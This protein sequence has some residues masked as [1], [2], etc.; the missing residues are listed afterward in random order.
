MK[1]KTPV[2]IIALVLFLI[3]AQF[4]MTREKAPMKP[5]P[6]E[7]KPEI[8]Q[9]KRAFV[10]TILDLHPSGPY[11]GSAITVLRKPSE[12]PK[13]MAEKLAEEEAKK[14]KMEMNS[15]KTEKSSG[16]SAQ[17]QSKKTPPEETTAGI[18]KTN[19][20]PTEAEKKKMRSENILLW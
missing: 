20:Y 6:E 16:S 3:A 14:E 11:N 5:A 18:T 4:L 7:K 10:P 15:R 1:P 9:P 2:L 17:I 19:K 8:T 12:G 13:T